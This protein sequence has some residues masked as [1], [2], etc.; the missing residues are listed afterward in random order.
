MDAVQR[1]GSPERM[2]YIKRF[3][4]MLLTFVFCFSLMQPPKAKASAVATAA[5]SGLLVQLLVGAG[6]TLQTSELARRVT[7]DFLEDHPEVKQMLLDKMQVVKD[8]AT[9]AYKVVCDFGDDLWQTACNWVDGLFDVGSNN[10]ELSSTVEMVPYSDIIISAPANLTF[11]YADGRFDFF[12][13]YLNDFGLCLKWKFANG[14]V[15][16]LV[17]DANRK[18]TRYETKD[19]GFA[20][21]K[22]LSIAFYYNV[23]NFGD[24]TKLYGPWVNTT[25]YPTHLQK[26][27]SV[28]GTV[29][30]EEHYIDDVGRE[31]DNKEA[32]SIS[33]PL[34]PSTGGI[35]IGDDFYD[36]Q[37]DS[38]LGWVSG[39]PYV[40]ADGVAHGATQAKTYKD[41]AAQS[42]V[43]GLPL[44]DDGGTLT[45]PKADAQYEVGDAT[46]GQIQTATQDSTLQ[47]L[48]ITRFPFSIPWDFYNALKLLAAPP[49]VPHWEV[50]FMAPIA[51]R[52]G[53]WKGNTTIVIDFSEYE[54]LGQLSRWLTTIMFVAALAMGTKKL[55]WTA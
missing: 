46:I 29:V 34:W 48:L 1:R 18:V 31:W 21:G 47:A 33:V 5:V 42:K 53:G 8:S 43:I 32:R 28:T 16:S 19:Y 38:I 26:P 51:H 30:G 9:G 4:C 39:E 2:N 17:C 52:V 24:T 11:Y 54:L 36:G 25:A 35:A 14:S 41:V 55:M 6:V 12:E 27:V 22:P 13:T 37:L 40:D 3:G 10:Y 15:G 20:G 23:T 49:K 45:L 7:E 50:D 44:V